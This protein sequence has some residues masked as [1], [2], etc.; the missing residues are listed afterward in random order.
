MI[1]I[2]LC[3]RLCLSVSATQ[4]HWRWAKEARA[5]SRPLLQ[6]V[7]CYHVIWFVATNALTWS[8][9]KP[10]RLKSKW[11]FVP[12]QKESLLYQMGKTWGHSDSDLWGPKCNE[13][14]FEF[15]WTFAQNLKMY[16]EGVAEM[17]CSH[18]RSARKDRWMDRRRENIT[19]PATAIA[20][21]DAL[22][23]HCVRLT[24]KPWMI[25]S[26]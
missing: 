25:F 17:M 12:S 11:M 2:D 21:A 7:L 9:F 20:G 16:P 14:I 8:S 24:G 19:P 22:T 4:S 5:C 10:V 3:L 1:N 13:F 26:Y 15:R 18:K 23:L 6:T